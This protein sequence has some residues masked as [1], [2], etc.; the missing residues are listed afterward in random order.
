MIYLPYFHTYRSIPS[1]W[2]V[3]YNIAGWVTYCRKQPRVFNNIAGA[4]FIFDGLFSLDLDFGKLVV[5]GVAGVDNRSFMVSRLSYKDHKVKPI[6]RLQASSPRAKTGRGGTTS[7]DRKD[8]RK[9]HP[10]D[11]GMEYLG[12]VTG[13]V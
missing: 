12:S 2:L 4:P 5:K 9:G 11:I 6:P 10:H 13:E 3:F 1:N 7:Q 8:A